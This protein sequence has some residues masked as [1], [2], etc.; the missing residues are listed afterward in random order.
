MTKN[1]AVGFFRKE[2][3]PEVV[4]RYG[5]SDRPAVRQAWNDYVDG[6]ARRGLVTDRQ[7]DTWSSPFG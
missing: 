6:L 1:E 7:R 3:L 4:R 5:F 2:I